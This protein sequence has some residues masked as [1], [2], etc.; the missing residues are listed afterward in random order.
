MVQHL[1]KGSYTS[2]GDSCPARCGG[3]MSL[4]NVPVKIRSMAGHVLQ[5]DHMTNTLSP[6][7]INQ[8][9]K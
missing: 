7:K 3:V 1:L 5:R 4:L 2:D 9:V 6:A 8:F